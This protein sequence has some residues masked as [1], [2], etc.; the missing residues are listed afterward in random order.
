M[1]VHVC[2]YAHSASV[3]GS[4]SWEPHFS[5]QVIGDFDQQDMEGSLL[6]GLQGRFSSPLERHKAGTFRCLW[7]S[8]SPRLLG[9]RSHAGWEAT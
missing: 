4:P 7:V 8:P 9:L 5:F 1:Y 6:R 2:V 3:G